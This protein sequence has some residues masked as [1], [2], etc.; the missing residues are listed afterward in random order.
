M[1]KWDCVLFDLD[2][3]LIDSAP[4]VTRR[5]AT[6]FREFGVQVPPYKEL[7]SLLG[8]SA[9]MTMEKYLGIEQAHLGLTFFRELSN[10]EGLDEFQPFDGVRAVLDELK[11]S[12]IQLC[13]ATSKPQIDAEEILKRNELD[14]YFAVVSGAKELEGMHHKADVIRHALGQVN[15][16]SLDRCLMVGDRFYDVEGASECG[17]ASYFVAW[18]GAEI[19]ESFGALGIAHTTDEL[20]EF[21]LSASDTA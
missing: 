17:I 10:K 19:S 15:G 1:S 12:E 5:F 21:I 18:G 2:G 9:V 8:P 20:V 4:V 3:T 6:T 16:V 13:V 11:L 14:Q 7:H